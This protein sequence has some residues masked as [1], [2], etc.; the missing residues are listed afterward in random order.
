MT[1]EFDFTHR[2]ASRISEL[3]RLGD[4]PPWLRV[5]VSSGGCS[6]FRYEYAMTDATAADDV[7]STKGDARV[8][9]DRT[10]LEVLQGCVL[11]WESHLM[12][13]HFKMT[14]P[15][16]TSGCGCGASFYV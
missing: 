1:G 11:D 12:G 16:A 5:S 7:V 2:A 8:I 13:S 3:G 14:N 10:S 9:I 15:N 4:I 6:G